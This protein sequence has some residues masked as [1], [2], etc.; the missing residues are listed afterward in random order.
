MNKY[1][2]F[3]KYTKAIRM[4]IVVKTH[5]DR[6]LRKHPSEQLEVHIHEYYASHYPKNTI[7]YLVK[8]A[9][10]IPRQLMYPALEEVILN[11]KKSAKAREEFAQK[12]HLV[13]PLDTDFTEYLI[14]KFIHPLFG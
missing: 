10:A 8:L 2:K 7:D 12:A 3:G 14:V 4:L 11:L 1:L 9:E 13:P 6:Y 5:T